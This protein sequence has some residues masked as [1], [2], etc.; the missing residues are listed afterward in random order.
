MKDFNSNNVKQFEIKLCKVIAERIEKKPHGTK[1]AISREHEYNIL[2]LKENSFSLKLNS[3]IF[4]EPEA[5]F[6]INLEHIINYA[7]AHKVDAKF[8]EDNVEEIFRPVGSE[9]SY[10][11]STLTKFLTDNYFIMPPTITMEQEKGK[12]QQ[13]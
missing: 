9:V 5:L 13:K 12:K 4:L 11:T 2:D 10:I 1:L 7:F 8:I 6:C 3:K